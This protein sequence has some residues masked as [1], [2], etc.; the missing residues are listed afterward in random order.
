M[1]K[2]FEKLWNRLG[3]Q[4]GVTSLNSELCRYSEKMMVAKEGELQRQL[5]ELVKRG[6]LIIEEEHPALV[7]K[8]DGEIEISTKI[9]LTVKDMEYIK[10]L[11]TK[12]SIAERRI[13][14][15][16]QYVARYYEEY[17]S[18]D[19]MKDMDE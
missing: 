17:L 16:D 14:E 19:D 1:T 4:P 6:I 11:E 9:R 8:K 5:S 10:K 18:K 15:I 3:S 13:A 12:L 7:Q 2:Q